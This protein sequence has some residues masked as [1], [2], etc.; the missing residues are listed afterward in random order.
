MLFFPAMP[1]FK[2][3]CAKHKRGISKFFLFHNITDILI[4]PGPDCRGLSRFSDR[5]G[6]ETI[7]PLS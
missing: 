2:N 1:D 7:Y 3:C 6:H 5:V 4:G